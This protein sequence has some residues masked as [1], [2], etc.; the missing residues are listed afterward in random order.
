VRE[1]LKATVQVVKRD[2]LHIF[3]VIPKRWVVER[4]FAWLEECRRLWKNC[5]R[6]LN[7]S[8]QFAHLA[9]PCSATQKIVNRLLAGSTTRLGGAL[10]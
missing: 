1:K 5:G 3:A 6:K 8:P 9:F 2:Q 7:T 10:Q 4:S